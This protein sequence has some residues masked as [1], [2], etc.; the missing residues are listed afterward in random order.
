MQEAAMADLS[1]TER[2]STHFGRASSDG[3]WSWLAGIIGHYFQ[4][5]STRVAEENLRRL[6]DRLLAD[7]G[8]KRNEA[9][10]AVEELPE[11]LTAAPI[12][13]PRTAVGRAEAIASYQNLWR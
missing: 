13:S 1:Y 12:R 6:D 7:I 11:R 9:S 2:K 4:W 3:A 8:L 5:H 10:G